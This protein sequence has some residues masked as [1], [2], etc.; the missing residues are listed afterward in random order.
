MRRGE[1]HFTGAET[2]AF[3]DARRFKIDQARFAAG[4]HQTVVGDEITHRAESVAIE[5]HADGDA[6]AENHGGRAV[7]RLAF[8]REEFE[9]AANV[10]GKEGVFGESC[11]NQFEH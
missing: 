3:G 9:R 1:N 8:A 4:D 2:V 7:P 5:F 10:G 6:V 11:W